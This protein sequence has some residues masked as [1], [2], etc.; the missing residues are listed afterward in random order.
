MYPHEP[1]KV[2]SS[3]DGERW[4]DVGT[5]WVFPGEDAWVHGAADYV[6]VKREDGAWSSPMKREG[7]YFPMTLLHLR[8]PSRED[9]FPDHRHYGM[10]VL[11]RG[12]ESGRLLTYDTDGDT[13]TWTIQFRGE[14]QR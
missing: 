8:E 11:L 3:R 2:Q 12:G 14:R 5:A 7:E 10:P 9:R 4:L 6:R 13:W 1:W